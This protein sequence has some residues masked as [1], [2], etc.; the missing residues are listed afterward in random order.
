MEYALGGVA[1]CLVGNDRLRVAD[2]NADI[3][4][5]MQRVTARLHLFA[6]GLFLQEVQ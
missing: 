4:S 1:A 6:Y 2:R 3:V 5:E